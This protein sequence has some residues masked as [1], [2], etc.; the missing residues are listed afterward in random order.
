MMN[1][2]RELA[3][4]EGEKAADADQ[5]AKVLTGRAQDSRA[6]ADKIRSL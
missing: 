1:E 3:R 6:F 5:V 2:K 4:T